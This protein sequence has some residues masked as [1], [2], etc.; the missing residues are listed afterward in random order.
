MRSRIFLCALLALAGV[1]ASPAQTPDPT[2]EAWA[3]LLQ[4]MGRLRGEVAQRDLSAIHLEDPVASV[5]VSRLLDRA[6]GLTKVRLIEFVRDISALH[7]AADANDDQKCRDII[8]KAGA[9]FAELEKEVLPELMQAAR[10]LAERYTCPM[11]PDVRGAKD[12]KCPKCGMPLEQQVVLLPRQTGSLVEQKAVQATIDTD[13]PLAVGKPTHAVL[14][15]VRPGGDAVQ[16]GDLIETHTKKIHLLIIDE[17]LTDY[18]HE[19][20]RPTGTPG[21]YAFEFTPQKPGPYL[22]WADLRPLPLG[23]QEYDDVVIPS[24]EKPEPIADRETRLG[25]DVGGYH[26]ELILQDPVL[27]AGKPAD[28]RLKVTKEDGSGFDQLEPVMGAF[29]HVVGF[30]ENGKTVLHLHP[31]GALVLDESARGGPEL[32]LKIYAT[33]PGF[34]RLFAQVQIGG[35]QFFAP[36]NVTVAP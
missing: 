18:H 19:H 32:P 7:T 2:V 24:P 10:N 25:A 22:V 12:D 33:K 4:M 34:T 29:A 6:S 11:H 1:A 17:S 8:G 23:L 13:G 21:D 9:E 30:N 31:T 27:R 26:F 16:L 5:A 36:F 15:L 20:P 3:M 35:R 28:A 14:H